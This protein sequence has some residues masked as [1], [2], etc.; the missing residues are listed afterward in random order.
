MVPLLHFVA[1]LTA[2]CPMHS[3]LYR[4]IQH[5][6]STL[7]LF[8]Y[9]SCM[10]GILRF[11]LR[12]LND[13]QKKNYWN[14]YLIKCR[15]IW[16]WVVK[17]FIARPIQYRLQTKPQKTS[18]VLIFWSQTSIAR[19]WLNF[20]CL[21]QGNGFLLTQ[22]VHIEESAPQNI[23]L[24]QLWEFSLPISTCTEMQ[25]KAWKSYNDL[26]EITYCAF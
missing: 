5:L 14:R 21:L 20:F 13:N 6:W 23:W 18:H 11:G 17:C 26:R 3:K 16:V 19:N 8:F 4:A 2:L 10:R 15:N 24:R 1:P 25:R 7:Q 9:D 22:T 12:G